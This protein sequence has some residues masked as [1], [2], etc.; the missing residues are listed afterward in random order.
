MNTSQKIFYLSF[1]TLNRK[2]L[3]FDNFNLHR[4]LDNDYVRDRIKEAGMVP[5]QFLDDLEA[6][7]FTAVAINKDS[8]EKALDGEFC[9]LFTVENSFEL[10]ISGINS[11]GN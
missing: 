3:V 1:D 9:F 4:Y 5:A 6:G 8:G 10:K 11:A 2:Y 7:R